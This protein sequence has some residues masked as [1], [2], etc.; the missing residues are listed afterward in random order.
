MSQKTKKVLLFGAIALVVLLAVFLGLYFLNKGKG[1]EQGAKKITVEV[2]QTDGSKES[3]EIRTDAE[4]LKEALDEK[5]LIEGKDSSYGFYVTTVHGVKADSAKEE[6]W[7]IT[8]KGE[9]LMTGV[10]D[11]PIA[12]GDVFELTLTVGW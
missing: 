11:T 1:A 7:A 2:I 9:M 3:F 12:D 8:K 5:K 6:W 10:S 4:F